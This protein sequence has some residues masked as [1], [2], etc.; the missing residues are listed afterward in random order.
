MDPLDACN[1]CGKE[2]GVGCLL[3]LLGLVGGFLACIMVYVATDSANLAGVVYVAIVVVTSLPGIL[4]RRARD[5]EK[6]N[7]EY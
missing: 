3:P 7:S 4:R 2:L 1:S 5:K 6:K